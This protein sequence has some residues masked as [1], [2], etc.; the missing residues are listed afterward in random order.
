MSKIQTSI[1]E[2]GKLL[3]RSM[4]MASRGDPGYK[5]GMCEAWLLAY[6]SGIPISPEVMNQV[7]R[8]YN[9]HSARD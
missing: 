8:E 6:R 2:A 1:E 4:D 3:R 9:S 5:E 7:H